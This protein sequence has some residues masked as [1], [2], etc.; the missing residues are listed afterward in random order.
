MPSQRIDA[1]LNLESS[2]NLTTAYLEFV[3]DGQQLERSNLWTRAEEVI[4]G[5]LV[6]CLQ[7]L[8]RGSERLLLSLTGAG[9]P[10]Q[11]PQDILYGRLALG[12]ENATYAYLAYGDHDTQSA[13]LIIEVETEFLDDILALS[14]DWNS[15]R[16]C[17]VPAPTA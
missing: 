2:N 14:W 8:P 16:G 13:E 10:G 4:G 3:V 5:A 7:N 12:R 11:R 6:A 9:K 17:L 1:R 15:F